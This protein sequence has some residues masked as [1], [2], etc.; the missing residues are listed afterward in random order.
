MS[1]K[2]FARWRRECCKVAAGMLLFSSIAIGQTTLP[3]NSL[4][5][6]PGL[7]NDACSKTEFPGVWYIIT[8]KNTM[9]CN[10]VDEKWDIE[11]AGAPVSDHGGLTGLGDDDHAQY[12]LSTEINTEAKLEALLGG[13]NVIV[14]TEI[15]SEA[16]LEALIGGV[17][18]LVSTDINTSAKIFAIVS[19]PSG[20]GGLLVFTENPSLNDAVINLFGTTTPSQVIEGRMIWDTDDNELTIGTSISRV[21]FRSGPHIDG[22]SVDPTTCLA[23]SSEHVWR[24]VLDVAADGT[25]DCFQ[26]IADAG[27]VAG[28]VTFVDWDG[29]DNFK[30]YPGFGFDGGGIV[31]L[32]ES[33]LD[34]F[35]AFGCDSGQE[36]RMKME[37]ENAGDAFRIENFDGVLTLKGCDDTVF[38][39]SSN[40]HAVRALSDVIVGTLADPR[41]LKVTG[42]IRCGPFG[43]AACHATSTATGAQTAIELVSTDASHTG[44]LLQMIDE[45]TVVW[46]IEN[47][48]TLLSRLGLFGSSVAATGT[49]FT[50][51]PVT[52]RTTGDIVEFRDSGTW[53]FRINSAGNLQA[54]ASARMFF[55]F[56][57]DEAVYNDSWG[58]IVVRKNTGNTSATNAQNL[59]LNTNFTG[60]ATSSGNQRALWVTTQFNPSAA[61]VTGV[62]LTGGY[63]EVNDESTTASNIVSLYGQDNVVQTVSAGTTTI[64]EMAGATY[65]I[66]L[67]GTNTTVTSAYGLRIKTPSAPGTGTTIGH[68]G[69]IEINDQKGYGTSNAAIRIASQTGTDADKGNVHFVGG[70]FQ[71]GHVRLGSAHI[72][73][74]GTTL[75][76]RQGKPIS[77]TDGTDLLT[78]TADTSADTICSGTTTYLDGDGGCDTISGGQSALLG[79]SG[80]GSIVAKGATSFVGLGPGVVTATAANAEYYIPVTGTVENLR[81]YV[82]ANASNNAG[83]TVTVFKNGTG[84]SLLVSYGA[85]ATGLL[86]DTSNTVSVVAGDR[87][88]IEVVNTG[89]GGGTKD[90]V[91]E[92]ISLEVS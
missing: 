1:G 80:A 81:V 24:P 56:G 26:P 53:K 51:D 63:Y 28:N 25:L 60:D 79:H 91:V 13:V 85:T 37:S 54:H 9:R 40:E 34:T 68:L 27:S 32:A 76:G 92:T 15:S 36:C 10:P 88:S 74:N 70:N 35:I 66:G 44:D 82:S 89:S 46:S 50:F 59:R 72:W 21:R 75:Y 8:T 31:T 65:R 12:L 6:E 69:G 23:E 19:D 18:L 61:S 4:S 16:E 47:D 86:A 71:S 43:N 5:S 7:E 3:Y 41:N 58:Q 42:E 33:E 45:A 90:L 11:S 48:E 38:G 22:F 2:M 55:A 39:C 83:N 14:A 52:A 77:A 30:T 64:A 57:S 84:T 73:S 78:H 49:A 62:I 67:T 20:T 87:I 29:S 17:N